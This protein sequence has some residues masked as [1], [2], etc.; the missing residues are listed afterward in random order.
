MYAEVSV[1]V[2]GEDERIFDEDASEAA[3]LLADLFDA[4]DTQAPSE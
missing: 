1:V 3:D 4:L 2:D